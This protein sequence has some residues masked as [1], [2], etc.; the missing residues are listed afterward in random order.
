MEITHIRRLSILA[1]SLALVAALDAAQAADCPGNPQALG[2]SRTIVVDPVEHQRIGG[3]NYGETLPLADKEVVLTFDDGPLPPYSN[4]ILDILASECVRATYFIVGRMAKAYPELVRRA[5]AEGHTIGTHSMNHPIPYK[6]HGLERSKTEIEGGIAATGEALGDAEAVAPFFRFPGLGRT[7]PVEAYLGRRGLMAW[8]ADFPADDWR[9]IKAN[10]IIRR[11]LMRLEAKG[12]GILLLHDIQPA[13]ALALPTLLAE[14]KV[15]G[16]RIVHVQP[17]GGDQPKTATL[18]G[19]WRLKQPRRPALPELSL[20]G[21][22]DLDSDFAAPIDTAKLCMI[23]PADTVTAAGRGGAKGLAARA[24]AG[25]HGAA[26]RLA[27]NAGRRHH[28]NLD[29]VAHAPST[30]FGGFFL[31]PRIAPE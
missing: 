1:A 26:K 11:A 22:R 28:P 25:R 19:D 23:S 21:L 8:S 15:R 4:R 2:T 16:Y 7:D 18:P 27:R 10:E 9:R 14:L 17:A 31:G 24:T 3:M 12:R 13:T 5:H 6:S 20:A 30:P 29:H